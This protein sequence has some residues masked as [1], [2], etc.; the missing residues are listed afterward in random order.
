MQISKKKE[1]PNIIV[2]TLFINLAPFHL[3]MLIKPASTTN[4]VDSFPK[5]TIHYML[6]L[7]PLL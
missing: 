5:Q 2:F 4:V 6:V 3:Q 7:V 1:F